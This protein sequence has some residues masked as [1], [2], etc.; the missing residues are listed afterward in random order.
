MNDRYL[1]SQM[2]ADQ[3]VFIKTVS[4]FPKIAKLT[5]DFELIV[6]VLKGTVSPDSLFLI[7]RI[8]PSS[9]R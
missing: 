1:R 3:Y 6:K 7:I 4:G 2:D 9:S 8:Q 5:N